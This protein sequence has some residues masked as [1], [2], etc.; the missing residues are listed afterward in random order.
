MSAEKGTKFGVLAGLQQ[1]S[2]SVK[3]QSLEAPSAPEAQEVRFTNYLDAEIS[4]RLNI[5]VAQLKAARTPGIRPSIKS[6]LDQALRD[7]LDRHETK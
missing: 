2:K 3:Q 4:R 7:Y 6:V 5:H 1:S